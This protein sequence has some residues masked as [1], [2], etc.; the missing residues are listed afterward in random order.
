[1]SLR[2]NWLAMVASRAQQGSRTVMS[3]AMKTAAA[4]AESTKK[5][6]KKSGGLM[7]AA[8]VSPELKK[9]VGVSE[10]SRPEAVKKIWEH[11]KANN[12]QNPANKREIRCDEKLKSIFGRKENVTMFEISKLISPHFIK[13]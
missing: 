2:A 1:M 10:I 4:A 3:T 13:K 5:A 11:I 12:L 6:G 9:F 7:I 8:P